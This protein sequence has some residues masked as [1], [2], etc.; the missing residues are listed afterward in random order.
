MVAL[1]TP[2]GFGLVK[3]LQQEM[4]L[5]D[6]LPYFSGL[7]LVIVEGFKKG[8]QPKI[9]LVRAAA[10]TSPVLPPV[11]LVTWLVSCLLTV[12][13]RLFRSFNDVVA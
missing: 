7:D 6:I 13:I 9:E 12:A 11:E 5:A 2:S 10:S 3:K 1:A 4:P 8:P